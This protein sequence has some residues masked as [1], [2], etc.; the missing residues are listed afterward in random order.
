[1]LFFRERRYF[2]IS[3][4]VRRLVYIQAAVPTTKRL[5]VVN[6]NAAMIRAGKG[7][8]GAGQVLFCLP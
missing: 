3:S 5:E 1:M 8:P 6:I 4:P 7:D 2:G